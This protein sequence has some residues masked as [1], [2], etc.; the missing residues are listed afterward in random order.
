M[1]NM[2]DRNNPPIINDIGVHNL[3]ESCKSICRKLPAF[4]IGAR[5]EILNIIHKY[6][7]I[8]PE[9]G[10]TWESWYAASFDLMANEIGEYLQDR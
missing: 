7:A 9:D 2:I 8:T 1:S 10:E 4:G 3:C 6:G 5:R